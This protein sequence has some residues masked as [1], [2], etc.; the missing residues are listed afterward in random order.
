MITDEEA[1]AETIGAAVAK[2]TA[3]AQ[4]EDEAAA[5]KRAAAEAVLD[6]AR[7]RVAAIITAAEAEASPLMSAADAAER[8]SGQL[9]GTAQTLRRAVG[10]AAKAEAADAAVQALEEERAGLA[11]TLADLGRRLAELAAERRQAAVQLEAAT[12]LADLDRMTER[13]NRIGSI[14]D[15]AAAL[16]AQQAPLQ[17]RLG[18]I[19]DGSLSPIWPQKELYEARRVAGMDRRTLREM[20]NEAFP[21]RPEAVAAAN[22]AAQQRRDL[23]LSEAIAAE[24]E[25]EA[26]R[27]PRTFVAG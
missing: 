23:A 27:A 22:G 12:Q 26:R 7:Q 25:Q 15:L 1:T 13:R 2:M 3:E 9:A 4:A 11:A 18:A 8:K 14:D 20:L 16:T 24:R 21:D 5:E 6:D 19:G 17:A 10:Q